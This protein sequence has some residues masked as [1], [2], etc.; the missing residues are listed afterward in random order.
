[1]SESESTLR[2]PTG[3]VRTPTVYDDTPAE[4][5]AEPQAIVLHSE[6]LGI[7]TVACPWCSHLHLH[8]WQSDMDYAR[9][10]MPALCDSEL[11]GW[12]PGDYLL[13][14]TGGVPRRWL[15]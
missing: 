14:T 2:V 9:V 1:M 5:I 3:S 4:W 12:R 11:A 8:P 13:P 6:G 10:A 7:V 15:R